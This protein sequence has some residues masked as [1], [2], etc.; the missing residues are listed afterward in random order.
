MGHAWLAYMLSCARGVW[1]MDAV[2]A[3]TVSA[4]VRGDPK[5]VTSISKGWYSTTS[6]PKRKVPPPSGSLWRMA[7]LPGWVD[8]QSI[9]S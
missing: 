3:A 9:F 2:M 4:T 6:P 1:F 5:A 8:G 7:V